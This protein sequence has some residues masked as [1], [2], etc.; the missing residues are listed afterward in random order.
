MSISTNSPAKYSS[1]LQTEL[2]EENCKFCNWCTRAI[3]LSN[4]MTE[5]HNTYGLF[6][7]HTTSMNLQ[8]MHNDSI[9]LSKCSKILN[10]G[11]FQS[12]QQLLQAHLWI[13]GA[14][15][16]LFSWNCREKIAFFPYRQVP[17][18]IKILEPPL[19]L[20]IRRPFFLRFLFFVYFGHWIKYKYQNKKI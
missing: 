10:Y 8:M 7:I 5:K 2:H 17:S 14:P 3:S 15:G 20:E 16:I 6:C 1:V 13:L 18:P 9:A 19:T 11:R 4:E 12:R